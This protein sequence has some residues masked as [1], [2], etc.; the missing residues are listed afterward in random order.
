VAGFVSSSSAQKRVREEVE[1]SAR[2]K[3]PC[4]LRDPFLRI[5]PQAR[6]ILRDREV[7]G[8]VGVGDRFRVAVDERELELVLLLE[9]PRGG[10]LLLG[11]VDADYA[12]TPSREPRG[13]IRRAA[14]ELDRV[15]ALGVAGKHAELGLGHAP[16]SPGRRRLSPV[17]LT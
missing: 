3:Q 13:N 11:V 1:T 10:E 16:Y 5:H 14:A 6:A 17:P 9:A 15:L 2:A 4:R 12:G 8:L 7:E